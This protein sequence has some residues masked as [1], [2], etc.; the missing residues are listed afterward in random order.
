MTA[1]ASVSFDYENVATTTLAL[2]R[3]ELADNIFKA[4]PTI[5]MLMAA[6]KVE[7][8]DGGKWIEEPLMYAK[9]NTV[10]SYQGY[11]TLDVSPTEEFTMARFGI[12]QFA[13]SLSVSGLEDLQNA[14][15]AQV[16]DLVAKKMMNLEMSMKEYLDEIIHGD[17]STKNSKDFLGL[18]ELVED[19]AGASQGTVGGIDRSTYSWWRNQ[20]GTAGFGSLTS[21]MR[22]FYNECGKGNSKPNLIVTDYNNY[23]AY[24]D[25]NAGKLR[26]SDIGLMDAGFENV[27]FRRA[28]IV[29]NENCLAGLMYF[30]NLEHLRL[31]I[32]RRRNFA[33]TPFRSPID[34]DARVAQI[35]VAGNMTINNGRH[36]G[37][38]EVS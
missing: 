9:N 37:V 13:G 11:D 20:Y 23:E 33:M 19:V 28:T 31:K 30:L 1:P 21:R 10:K 3:P 34:Q 35:L 38:L 5:A 26:V 14:G 12:R 17:S 4:N 36:V 8:F 24:E 22:S 16:M 6:G 15:E 29:P 18:D 25:Q 27:R 7:L 2:I 32:H